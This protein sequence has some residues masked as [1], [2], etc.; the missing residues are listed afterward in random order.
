MAGGLR[1]RVGQGPGP[2]LAVGPWLSPLLLGTSF[3]P[4]VIFCSAV[5]KSGNNGPKTLLFC[6]S[7]TSLCFSARYPLL[8]QT[9]L[10]MPSAASGLSANERAFFGS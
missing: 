3:S 7:L 2:A 1:V 6:V 5:T 4:S 10:W 9:A 8:S